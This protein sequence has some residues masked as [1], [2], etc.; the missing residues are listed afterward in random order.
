MG[1][2]YWG[3]PLKAYATFKLEQKT[4]PRIRTSEGNWTGQAHKSGSC[5]RGH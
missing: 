5:L 3:R 2:Q 1:K 4:K